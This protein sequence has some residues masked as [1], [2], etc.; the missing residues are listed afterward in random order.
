MKHKP[1]LENFFLLGLTGGTA[2]R[3]KCKSLKLSLY[4]NQK[5]S[6][7]DDSMDINNTETITNLSSS[8]S[9]CPFHKGAS[10]FDLIIGLI[11][12][13]ALFPTILLNTFII[14]AVTKRR[15]L[16]KPSNILLSS[17]AITDLLN[18]VIV[19][20]ISATSDFFILGQVP[21]EYICMLNAV[22]MF[23]GPL[24]FIA[25][26]H[27]LTIIAWE[28][29]MAVQKW[30][31]YKRKI[32]N[33]RLKRIAIGTWLSSLLPTV[34]YFTSS[35]VAGDPAFFGLVVTL[36]IALESVCLFLV[37][38][39]YRKVYIGICNRKLNEISQID[40]LMKAKLESKV[41]KTTGL[42]S[43]MVISS[44][45]PIFVMA[46]LGSVV[47][48]FRSNAALRFTQILTQLTSLLNPL[49]YCYRDH[50]FRNALRELLGM[51]KSEATQL[52]TGFAQT[53]KRQ[54]P[55]RSSELHNL[56][57]RTQRL[58]RSAS[59]DLSNPIGSYHG[60]PSEV[61]LRR[62]L[63]APDA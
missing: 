10:A 59:C 19:M 45:I 8:R 14:L 15:E 1:Y 57:K 28:R 56:E 17:M 40:D 9:Y 63:S 44:F 20:P 34:L 39:F 51:E 55:S 13:I 54:D 48:V 42:L 35:V 58:K 31:E 50:R 30:M 7:S 25:T 27:H 18:G 62:S 29:Y 60:T 49:L 53:S 37:A 24:L 2:K 36:W 11:T 3:S 43:A 22:N 12:T 16:Q 5:H 26:L 23:F 4:L 32:T 38:F 33:G 47:P 41:A 46:V 61:K 52:A 6:S 21:Y